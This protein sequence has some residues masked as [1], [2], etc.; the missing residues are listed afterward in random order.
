MFGLVWMTDGSWVHGSNVLKSEVDEIQNVTVAEGNLLH[1]KYI[2]MVSIGGVPSVFSE[3]HGTMF[4][5]QLS[6]D[7]L[8]KIHTRIRF[9]LRVSF[10][11][12]ER[13]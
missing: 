3:H 8:Q 9:L 7:G 6:S 12:I 1:K 2:V 13:L 11:C 10:S 5:V 4:L